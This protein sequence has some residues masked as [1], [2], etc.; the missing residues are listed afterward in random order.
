MVFAVREP[1]EQFGWMEKNH[2]RV[3]RQVSVKKVSIGL[4]GEM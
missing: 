1:V 4:V 3:V 2:E